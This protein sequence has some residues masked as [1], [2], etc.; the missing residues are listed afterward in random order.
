LLAAAAGRPSE[1]VRLLRPLS[2][3]RASGAPDLTQPAQWLL[4]AAY[5]R[6][7]HLDSSAAQLERLASW[8]GA[9]PAGWRGL[10]HSFAHQRLVLLY[11]RLGRLE[12]ARRHW[13]IFSETFTSPDPELQHLVD[14]ARAA[15][16]SAERGR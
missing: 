8:Q 9:R 12:D 13:K 16:A 1:V 14:E 15:L 7:G 2:D 11:A 3:G 10:T 6:Q 4:A 5:E